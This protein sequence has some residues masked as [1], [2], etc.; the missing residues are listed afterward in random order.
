MMYITKKNMFQY[1]KINLK[2]KLNLIKV[3]R[4]Y[5]SAKLK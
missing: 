1:N 2:I 4:F 3:Y 5:A